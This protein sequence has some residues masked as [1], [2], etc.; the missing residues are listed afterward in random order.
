MAPLQNNN[1]FFWAALFL[2]TASLL[3]APLFLGGQK[4]RLKVEK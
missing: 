4:N 1:R 3:M 2:G